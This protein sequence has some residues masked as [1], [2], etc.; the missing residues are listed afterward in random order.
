MAPTWPRETLSTTVLTERGGTTELELT[1]SAHNATP[2]KQ[3]TF[4][5]AHA[6]MEQGW[7]GT[8][9]QLVAYLA[10]SK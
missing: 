7:S 3:A 4:D 6:G 1:W 10:K 8:F 5:G 2:E 9:A